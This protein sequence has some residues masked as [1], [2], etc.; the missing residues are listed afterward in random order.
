MTLDG[1]GYTLEGLGTEGPGGITLAGTNNV[2]VKNLEVKAFDNGM[3]LTTGSTGNVLVGNNVTFNRGHG[4]YLVTAVGNIIVDNDVMDNGKSAV[5]L[6]EQS[7]QNNISS[8]TLARNIDVGV[9]LTES[10]NNYVA[11]NNVTDNVHDGIYI[12]SSTN[13]SIVR[14]T[15]ARNGE[16]LRVGTSTK[17]HFG[18]N[19][20]TENDYEFWFYVSPGNY[21]YHNSFVGNGYPG[22]LEPGSINTWDLGY[23]AGGN[24]WSRYS[25][26]DADG[27]EIG[28]TPFI[29]NT[30]NQ[31]KYPLMHPWIMPAHDVAVVGVVS[32]KTVVGLGSYPFITL[33]VGNQGL[34]QEDINFTLN[35]G[36]TVI[37]SQ[38]VTVPSGLFTT[39]T[40]IWNTTLE[41]MGNNTLSAH[42]EQVSGETDVA[43]NSLTDGFVIIA[44]LGDLT[45]L[46][47]WPDGKVDIR[48]L[49]VAAKAFGSY[50]GHAKWNPNADITGV[51]YLVPDDKVDIRDL[52]V[53]AKNYGKTSSP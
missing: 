13:N 16:G 10:S 3:H 8:N 9:S 41:A 42:V 35:Y 53:M 1:A 27:D 36:S 4:I 31:D 2:T 24:F 26:V 12:Y 44:M 25:G 32:T 49:A 33:S 5:Y 19:N 43:D 52:A 7:S 20:I 51:D 11:R 17:N 21:I 30:E 22:I 45:G 23:P 46:G 50:P 18:A 29:I 34:N 15:I 6:M 28:D 38:V 14:N 48:D 47:G 37:A 40:L 39:L